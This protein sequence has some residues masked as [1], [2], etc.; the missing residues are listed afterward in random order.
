LTLARSLKST[1]IMGIVNATPDSFS[2]GGAYDP[3]THA[4]R[5]IDEGADLIDIG[6]EST[7]PGA[8]AIGLE[9]ESLRVLPVIKALRRVYSG[10]ISID[11]QKPELAFRAV[12]AGATIWNDVNGL[13]SKGAFEVLSELKINV[14]IMHMQ[15][16][17]A[18]MQK[19]PH[20]DDVVFEVEEFLLQQAKKA[21]QCGLSKDQIILDPGLGFGKTLDHNLALIRAIPRLKNHGFD[22]LIGASNKSMIAH[23]EELAGRPP[24]TPDQRLAGTLAVHLRAA[25]L[26]ADIVRVHNVAAHRQA[27][28]VASCLN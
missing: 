9:E 19:E 3:L 26:G 12:E 25:E 18:N 13:K 17:P 2:D 16:D 20:Y 8:E 5:L 11:T 4:L 27:F 28:L 7:R 24:S 14:I 6:G 15:N 22:V 23:C 1:K 10:H 21:L